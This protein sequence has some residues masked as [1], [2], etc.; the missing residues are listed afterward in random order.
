MNGTKQLGTMMPCMTRD[1]SF[2]HGKFHVNGTKK[3]RYH[4][5]VYNIRHFVLF[6]K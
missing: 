6:W 4:D 1:I 2:Y 5:G 3:A